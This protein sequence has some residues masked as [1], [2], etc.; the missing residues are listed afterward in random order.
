MFLFRFKFLLRFLGFKNW[1]TREEIK[2]HHKFAVVAEIWNIFVINLR[3]ANIPDDCIT[4][5]EE[6]VGYRGRISGRT[7]IP[8]KPRKYGLKMFWACE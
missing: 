1:H 8:S 4:V 5:D 2:V 6:L 7:Y 3:R